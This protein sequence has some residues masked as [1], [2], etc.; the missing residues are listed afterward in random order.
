LTLTRFAARTGG[1]ETTQAPVFERLAVRAE[2]GP[3][4]HGWGPHPRGPWRAGSP[5]GLRVRGAGRRRAAV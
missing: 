1:S 5:Q 3:A 4:S 2:S